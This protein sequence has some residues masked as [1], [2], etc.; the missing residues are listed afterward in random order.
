M[1]ANVSTIGRFW[2]GF[3]PGKW[4]AAGG[5]PFVGCT[6]GIATGP[7]GVDVRYWGVGGTREGCD[8]G[9]TAGACVAP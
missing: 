7:C 5:C 9:A 3:G 4:L 8:I 1:F 2:A 6:G